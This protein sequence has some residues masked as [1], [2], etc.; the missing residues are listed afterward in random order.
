MKKSTSIGLSIA[1]SLLSLS[2]LNA[3][4][5][6]SATTVSQTC[7]I[8]TERLS[9]ES[10][11]SQVTALQKF[12]GFTTFNFLGDSGYGYF[13]ANTENL[14]RNFQSENGLPVTGVVDTETALK[15]KTISCALKPVTTTSK[16]TATTATTQSFSATANYRGKVLDEQSK[17]LAG[18]V[19]EL[20]TQRLGFGTIYNNKS[21]VT[22]GTDGIYTFTPQQSSQVY[23]TLTFTKE[24]YLEDKATLTHGI[25]L[26]QVDFIL[27]KLGSVAITYHWVIVSTSS[28][29][30][31]LPSLM[32][33]TCN[34]T[35]TVGSSC[36]PT[37]T[38]DYSCMTS[39]N[40][41]RT[42]YACAV[43]TQDK[44]LSAQIVIIPTE[45]SSSESNPIMDFVQSTLDI[46]RGWLT[47]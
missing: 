3:L 43:V 13:G 45:T 23:Q 47:K 35:P 26:K 4:V 40:G 9:L 24:G 41:I 14:V 36:N 30:L 28:A 44:P 6:T 37:S 42:G 8:I 38:K 1:I 2:N 18:V 12:L 31:P 21:R 33:P 10:S 39:L 5:A 34:P 20:A 29:S 25:D 46:V 27:K 22:T 16:P 11:G 15:I 7:V 19:V 17:A 32:P